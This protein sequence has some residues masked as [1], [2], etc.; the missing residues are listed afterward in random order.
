MK[1]KGFAFPV[2]PAYDFVTRVVDFIAIPQNWI[3]D[4]KGGWRWTQMGFGAD[5]TW[6]E[7][8]LRRL[9]SVK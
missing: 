1:E 2:L 7:D 4:P 8:M 5:P 6:E 3:V 9:E